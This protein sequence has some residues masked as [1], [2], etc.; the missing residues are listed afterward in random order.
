MPNFILT[1]ENILN[2]IIVGCLLVNKSNFDL[3]SNLLLN[4]G[5]ISINIESLDHAISEI[6]AKKLNF[7]L[8]DIDFPDEKSYTLLDNIKS[9]NELKNI[10][11]IATSI[12]SNEKL[13]KR[14]QNYNIITFIPKPFNKN[15][16]N[17]KI[18]NLFDKTKDHIPKRKHIRIKPFD[19]E[20]IRLSFKLK[21]KK[22]ITA[23]VIDV[24]MGGVAC[25]M[26]ANYADRE[27][28]HGTLI[29]HLIFELDNKEVDVDAKVVTKKEKFIAFVFTHFYGD[30]NK[31]LGKY[32]QKKISF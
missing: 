26:Y 29:E 32:I 11:I 17:E 5:I 3:I 14:L 12:N 21:N 16:L 27:L 24:S 18:K 10:F 25:L 22:N 1:R 30:S 6:K 8:I 13:I 19:D 31:N 4:N 20:F 28:N 23:K 15:N 2:Q 7:L 9:D